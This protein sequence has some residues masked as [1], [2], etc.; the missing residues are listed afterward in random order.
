MP[1]ALCPRRPMPYAHGGLCP[2]PDSTSY[3][4][5][6]GYT[7]LSWLH[8]GSHWEYRVIWTKLAE[9]TDR[10]S[11]QEAEL[12]PLHLAELPMRAFHIQ[13]NFSHPERLC[14]I[15][16]IAKGSF[17]QHRQVPSQSVKRRLPCGSSNLVRALTKLGF[18]LSQKKDSI[19]DR[20]SDVLVVTP[21]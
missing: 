19:A 4:S 2:M 18:R 7:S 12:Q 17:P 3:E 16:A 8:H 20:E 13:Q 9:L 5:S 14:V 6:K 11:L 15:P 21:R 10:R 1:Y